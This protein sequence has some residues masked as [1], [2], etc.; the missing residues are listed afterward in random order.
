M[1]QVR[2]KYWPLHRTCPGPP[3]PPIAPWAPQCSV[4]ILRGAPYHPLLPP[5]AVAVTVHPP[6]PQALR[7]LL[8]ATTG[9]PLAALQRPWVAPTGAPRSSPIWPGTVDRPLAHGFVDAL[10]SGPVLPNR[11]PPRVRAWWSPR[12]CWDE[13][14]LWL[15]CP[16]GLVAPLRTVPPLPGAR[17]LL[18]ML[19]SP[20]H[21]IVCCASPRKAA[22][23]LTPSHCSRCLTRRCLCRNHTLPL[24]RSLALGSPVNCEHG[25]WHIRVFAGRATRVRRRC[26]RHRCVWLVCR[27]CMTW[28]RVVIPPDRKCGVVVLP[29]HLH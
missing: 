19:A 10:P 17:A 29:I 18:C 16:S 12:Q 27:A 7:R 6:L 25:D 1:E 3:H 2:A 8:H 23:C 9:C 4:L 22:Q 5:P 26:S 21:S 14:E 24:R 13:L 28:R 20:G 11:W 15:T